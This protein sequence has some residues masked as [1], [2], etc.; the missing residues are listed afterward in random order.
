MREIGAIGTVCFWIIT[1]LLPGALRAQMESDEA[2]QQPPTVTETITVTAEKRE[3]GLKDIGVTVSVLTGLEI[4]ELGLEHPVDIAAQTANLDI[5]ETFGNTNPVITIRGVGLNDFN[6][7]NNP[8]AGLYVD[9][10]FLTST[11]LMDFQLFD[12]ERVEVLKGPQGTLY[13]RNTTAGAINFITRGPTRD[14][15]AGLGVD[16]GNFDTFQLDG[17]VSGGLSKRLFGRLAATSTQRSGGPYFNRFLAE[18]HG[19][20]DRTSLR[21]SLDVTPDARLSARLRLH[22]GQD[23]SDG[24]YFEHVGLRAPG[25]FQIC[26]AFLARRSDPASCVDLGGYSDPDGDPF[27]GDWDLRPELDNQSLGASLSLSWVDEVFTLTSVTGYAA[28]DRDQSTENDSSPVVGLHNFYHHELFQLSQELRFTS[29]RP[30]AVGDGHLSWIA[31]GFY[32][33]DEVEGDPGQILVSEAWFFTH[34]AVEWQQDTET[35]AGFAHFDWLLSDRFN[36]TFGARYTREKRDFVGSTTDLNPFGT[37][38]ILDPFCNPGFVGPVVLARADDRISTSDLSGKLGFELFASGDWTIYA[39]LSKGFK[40]GGFNGSFAGSDLELDPFDKEE[41]YAAEVGF[42]A[43]FAGGW[44]SANASGFFYDYRDLQVFTIRISEV[45]IPTVVLTNASDAE[46]LG[47]DID[48]WARPA[49]GFDLKLGLGLLDSELQ[50]FRSA[51]VDYSGNQLANAPD[52]TFSGQLHYRFEISERLG[53]AIG[54]DWSFQDETFKEVTNSPIVQADSYWLLGAR[55]SLDWQRFGLALWGRN[56]TD[57]VYITDGG[58]QSAIFHSFR[59]YGLPRTYG[60]TW[61]LEW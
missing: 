6:P 61:T 54:L 25:T 33:R 30:L 55:W 48:L 4:E 26:D 59:I 13:G 43:T 49:E 42:K 47:A 35:A 50:D 1:G 15:D 37:S 21:L 41:L 8:A 34:S 31:G 53:S 58:D 44:V 45:G 7:N 3:E 60:L 11:S 10:V 5:K 16:L 17:V 32:S 23:R 36:L 29:N 46:I 14:F 38:C 27:A 51:G 2:E 22:A 52:L 18:E 9:E 40:S 28:F 19:E 57:E 20:A 12:V 24:F 39:S 56:L